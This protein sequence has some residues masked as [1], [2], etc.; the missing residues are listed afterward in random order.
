[1]ISVNIVSVFMKILIQNASIFITRIVI[2][3]ATLNFAGNIPDYLWSLL[4]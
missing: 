1:M 2:K 3:F 4:F